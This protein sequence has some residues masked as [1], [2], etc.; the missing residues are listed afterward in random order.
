[1]K[2]KFRLISRCVSR[3]DVQRA[4]LANPFDHRIDGRHHLLGTA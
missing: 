2:G 1:M 4:A 3:F